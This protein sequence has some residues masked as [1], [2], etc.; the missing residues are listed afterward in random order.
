[1]QEFWNQR[2]AEEEYAYGTKPNA[3][4]KSQLDQLKP[5]KILLPAEGEGRNAVYAATKGWNV[6]AF[7]FSEEGKK[8]AD[9]LAERLGVTIKYKV[10]GFDQIDYKANYFDV[11][12]LIFA[13]FPVQ[14]RK[15]FHQKLQSLL[16]EDGTLILEGFSKK[17]YNLSSGGPKNIDMLFTSGQVKRDFNQ[18]KKAKIFDGEVM[19]N[20]GLYHQG[21]AAVIQFVGKKS[22]V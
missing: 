21:M 19:L 1:M 11:I 4:F 17:Q 3:F 2:Y 14:L 10:A 6:F 12:A 16:K 22:T 5:G 20:E 13:H 7:D 9:K 18:I 15:L 8:K